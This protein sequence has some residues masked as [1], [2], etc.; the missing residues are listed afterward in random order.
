MLSGNSHSFPLYEVTSL[1]YSNRTK[2]YQMSPNTTSAAPSDP[3]PTCVDAVVSVQL[4][5]QTELLGTVLTLV[6]FLSSVVSS[7]WLLFTPDD[8]SSSTEPCMGLTY[9]DHKMGCE[10]CI[11]KPFITE[12]NRACSEAPVP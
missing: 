2:S 7:M 8:V 11:T 6:G 9:V 1:S 10:H 12:T 3:V 5:F 4:V